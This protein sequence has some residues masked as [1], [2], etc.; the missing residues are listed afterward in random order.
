MLYWAARKLV[1]QSYTAKYCK[2]HTLSTYQRHG[3]SSPFPEARSPEVGACI[4]CR[5]LLRQ[6]GKGAD[7]QLLPHPGGQ[8][9]P[10]PPA[11][12]VGALTRL[13]SC[14]A[15]PLPSTP[16]SHA[17][18]PPPCPCRRSNH[19]LVQLAKLYLCAIANC[20]AYADSRAAQLAYLPLAAT[21]GL[22]LACALLPSVM[23]YRLESSMRRRYV[24]N[25]QPQAAVTAD[26]H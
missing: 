4:S 19:L 9:P 23:V 12:Q 17:H 21:S 13:L 15:T 20:F 5:L 3:S 2:T 8:L 25:L 26:A 7:G 10:Q 16:R 6:P 18:L 1:V 22:Q 11:L 24:Q 14:V